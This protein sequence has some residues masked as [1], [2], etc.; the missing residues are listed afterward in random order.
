MCPKYMC[1]AVVL[2]ILCQIDMFIEG[3]SSMEVKAL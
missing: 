1:D 3:F 2:I